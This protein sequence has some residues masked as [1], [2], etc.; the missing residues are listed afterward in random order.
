[1]KVKLKQC[2]NYTTYVLSAIFSLIYLATMIYG[3]VC[4]YVPSL[5]VPK[6]QAQLIILQ[7]I[8]GI[9]IPLIPY[10]VL[11]LFNMKLTFFI[12]L[13][14]QLFGLFGIVLGEGFQLYY[15]VAWWDQFLHTFS[16]FGVAFIGYCIVANIIKDNDNI[17]HKSVIA[18]TISVLLSFSVGFVWEIYE[19]TCD[20][21]F[22]TNMQ[23]FMPE[24]SPIFNG[25]NTKLPLDGTA[26]EIAAFFRTPEG[27]RYALLDTMEDMICCF[28]GTV[29]FNLIAYLLARDT[30]KAFDN[31][32]ILHYHKDE[33]ENKH[34]TSKLEN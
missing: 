26:E 21:I 19:F 6:S 25:G 22:G 1:M 20:S 2:E 18:V 33:N 12:N 3:I 5:N 8:G 31:L 17:R 30:P 10:I 9:I 16:G 32:I 13:G 11:K 24:M 29:F 15:T 34:F 23:K 14:I 27:Y 4:I 7:S 28:C